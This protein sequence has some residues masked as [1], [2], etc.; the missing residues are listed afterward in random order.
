MIASETKRVSIPISREWASFAAI[1]LAEDIFPAQG[2][3][4]GEALELQNKGTLALTLNVTAVSGINP[5]LTVDVQT[6]EFHEQDGDWT[7]VDSFDPVTAVGRLRKVFVGFDTWARVVVT[8]GGTTPSFT[9]CCSGK[10]Y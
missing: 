2:T 6:S 1:T 8:I 5:R 4:I 9:L 3:F 7:T 10:A